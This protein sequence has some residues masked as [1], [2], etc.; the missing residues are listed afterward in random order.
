MLEQERSFFDA[1]VGEWLPQHENRFALIKGEQI[2]GFFNS[3]EEALVEGAR[4]F[5]LSSFLVRPVAARQ[6]VINAPALALGLIEAT[7]QHAVGTAST[8]T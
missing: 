8:G 7:L 1:H 3:N 4:R 5:G 6:D 2:V